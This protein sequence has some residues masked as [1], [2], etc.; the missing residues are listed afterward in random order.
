MNS[1]GC[2]VLPRFL[3]GELPPEEQGRF[4][5][6]LAGCEA[7]SEEFRDSLQL[8]LLGQFT[9]E[10]GPVRSPPKVPQARAGSERWWSRRRV[11]LPAGGMLAALGALLL[12][13]LS[14]QEDAEDAAWLVPANGRHLEARLT[15]AAVD[16]HYQRYVPERSGP[17]DDGPVTA[18]PLHALSRLEA[19]KDFHGIATAYLLHGAPLQ[20]RAFL[21]RMP[22]SADRTCDLAVIAL[23]RARGTQA[24]GVEGAWQ[25]QAHLEDALQLLEGVLRDEPSHP[26]ALWNRALVLRELGLT[27]LAAESFEAVAKLGE[28]GW[29]E[30]AW[31][32]ARGL[33]DGT[34][35][36]GREWTDAS[37][38]TRE[39]LTDPG[40]RLPLDVA[41]THPG[42]VR[43]AFYDVVRAASSREAVRRLMPL[44][45]ALDAG[46]GGDVHVLA[47]Y[48]R[49]VAERDF[50]LRGPAARRYAR[51]LQEE[52]PASAEAGAEVGSEMLEALRR[53]GEEDLLLGALVRASTAGVAVD[54]EL[55]A[56]LARAQ[57]DSWLV[58]QAEQAWARSEARAGAWWKAEQRL[59]AALEACQGAALVDRCL[60]LEQELTRLYLDLH[61]PAEALPYA[62]SGWERAKL[63]RDWR[64]EQEFLL[65]LADVLRFQHAFASAR[66]YLEEALARMPEDCEPRSRVHRTLAAVEWERFHP[67][68]AR[69]ALDRAL[70]C[71]RPLELTGALVLSDLA[72]VRPEPGDVDHLR[73]ALSAL[74]RDAGP[75]GREALLLSLE[76]QFE[77]ARSRGAGQLLLWRA[78]E[79]AEQGP[80]AVDA[81]LARVRAYGALISEAARTDGWSEVLA[82]QGRQL[83]MA[84]VPERCVLSVSV[85]HE[86]TVVVA[87]GPSGR[88]QGY[89]D[90]SRTGPPREAEALVPEPLVEALRGCEHVDVLALP[91]VH[92][93]TGLL[94]PDLAWSY[95][96]GRSTPA[97][98]PPARDA[99]RHLVVTEVADPPSLKLPRLPRLQ[100]PR[101]P[102]PLRME[103]RGS[104]ATPSRVLEAMEDAS[105]VELHAHGM[106]SSAVSDA[107][108]VVLAPDGDGRYALTADRV[109]RARLTRAPVVLLA[110]C[111]AARTAPYLSEPSSLPVAFIEAGASV[112]LAST[113]DIPDT[114]GAFFEEVRE[115]IRGNARPSTALRDARARWLKEHPGDAWWLT[116]VLL[117]E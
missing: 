93:F 46:P 3:D 13:T 72:R 117:F 67:D 18:L 65:E 14:R 28:S 99:A 60:G 62:W 20:A 63:T 19:R 6:H 79:L 29:S 2:E 11:W 35:A 47:G 105:E 5:E 38:A 15:Y 89:F 88:L 91:P 94:P 109:R 58:L 113:T 100:S 104:Q 110:T 24:S 17:E 37:A 83:R 12:L 97:W 75:P 77:L 39:L 8:E 25:R 101:V 81:R 30:E 106:F 57:G 31:G 43:R 95:R 56:R 102:D 68:D 71:E 23:Q 64:V 21:E 87:R 45:E 76:G 69:R 73:R 32:L 84:A 7:C 70:A 22:R 49:R 9:L 103:L 26:Q 4:R 80:D 10:E 54:V 51:L 90:A 33:R 116:H 114:A 112:V 52:P 78:V 61:R 92:G 86:R 115:L 40:A 50:T 44:A 55:L 1:V 66:A 82:L 85:H 108:L 48:V 36:R 59:K 98:P 34:A 42:L 74:R 16:G 107:S 111:N 27:L 96:V 53:S 41:R